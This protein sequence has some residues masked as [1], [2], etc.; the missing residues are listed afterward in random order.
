[1]VS[2]YKPFIIKDFRSGQVNAREPWL[3]PE[4]A[5]VSIIN[6]FIKNGILQKRLGYSLLGD[7]GNFIPTENVTDTSQAGTHT[8]ANI[9]VQPGSIVMTDSSGP[10]QV[11]TDDGNG[12]L[13]GDGVGTINYDNGE[14]GFTWT[15]TPNSPINVAYNYIPGLPIMGIFPH[16]TSSG[17]A[18]LLAF[19][20][21]RVFE[22]DPVDAR[23]DDI[24]LLDTFN[25]SISNYFHVTN[26]NGT[27]YFTNNVDQ[28]YSYNGSILAPVVVNLGAGAIT[29]TSL[30]VFA[31]KDH[32]VTLRPTEAG[33][34]HG[35]RARWATAG[36]TDFTNDGF[37]D[38]PTSDL[39]TGAAF[40]GD[41]LIVYFERSI[42]VLKFTQDVNLVFRWQ[43]IDAFSGVIA[44]NSVV[45]FPRQIDAVSSTKIISTNGLNATVENLKIPDIVQTFN[46][47]GF[48]LI[49]SIF[50]DELDL[51]LI[52]YPAIESEINDNMIVRNKFNNSW[53]QF[54]IGFHVFGKW[55]VD[56]DLAWDDYTTE[57]WDEMEQIWDDDTTQ[58]GFPIVLGG[59]SSGGSVFKLNDTGADDDESI[60]FLARTKRLNPYIDEGFKA[61]LGWVD[62]LLTSDPTTTLDV[63]LFLDEDDV[64]YRTETITFSEAEGIK[65]WKRVYSGVISEFHSI[66]LSNDAIGQTPLIHAIIPYFRPIEGKL[67]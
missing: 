28:L 15:V 41:E 16:Y 51:H 47:E 29:F 38:A 63:T 31:Y 49:Y 58:A 14:M 57:F 30:L 34:L 5:F 7:V 12:V 17:S 19:D 11:I 9:P 46:Q 2:K 48:N 33:T 4:D 10:S 8:L 60:S 18:T 59:A 65:V 20:T 26:W 62:F 50:L 27:M 52:S 53:S 21:K 25:G 32:L 45:S 43:R 1:M 56:K 36:S 3:I 55:I 22:W 61:R 24:T 23:F 6:G 35:Q 54:D 37:V 67:N 64:P 39:I 44:T 66:E 13:L 40:L 42:W